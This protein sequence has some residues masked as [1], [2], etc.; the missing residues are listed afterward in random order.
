M[1]FPYQ[2]VSIVG[3]AL[4]SYGFTELNQTDW[5]AL[6]TDGFVTSLLNTTPWCPALAEDITLTAWSLA[7]AENIT[8][9]TWN[10]AVAENITLSVWNPAI[11]ENITVTG[12]TLALSETG[13]T[14]T[15]WIDAISEIPPSNGGKCC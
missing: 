7:T 1:A 6:L 11:A 10:L 15:S 12:W 5:L 4:N 13:V 14:M 3:N 8:L 2:E 9:T